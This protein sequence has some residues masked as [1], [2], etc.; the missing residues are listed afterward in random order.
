MQAGDPDHG[1]S[2]A[3]GK[4]V[5][6]ITGGLV[7]N[8]KHGGPAPGHDRKDP[9]LGRDITG[10]STMTIEMV[11]RYV[12]QHRHV[13]GQRRRQFE[14]VGAELKDIDPI[15]SHR[16]KLQRRSADITADL[17]RHPGRLQNVTDQRRGGRFSIG[18]GDTDDPGLRT[19]A[20]QQFDIANDRRLLRPRPLG[21]R[22][23]RWMGVRNARAQH[24]IGDLGEIELRQIADFGPKRRRSVAPLN[25]IVPGQHPR[26]A[27]D[28]RAN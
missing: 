26:T 17:R 25:M 20:D 21:D 12:Q 7:I 4:T 22:V 27:G 28:E 2:L 9:F 16:L 14:L 8:A 11:G 13:A 15:R 3:P 1:N 10:Q 24:Q 5:G 18:S 19:G 6:Q 23:R